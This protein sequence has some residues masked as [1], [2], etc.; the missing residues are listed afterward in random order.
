MGCVCGKLVTGRRSASALASKTVPTPAPK[1]WLGPQGDM[2][3]FAS[4]AQTVV[5]V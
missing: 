1:A 5:Q 4:R 3:P 2:K